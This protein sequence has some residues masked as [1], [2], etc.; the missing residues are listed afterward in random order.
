[1]TGEE[2]EIGKNYHD[3]PEKLGK[4]TMRIPKNSKRQTK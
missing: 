2:S 3:S 1:M 4:S